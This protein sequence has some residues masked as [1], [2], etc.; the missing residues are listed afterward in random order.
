M[1]WWYFIQSSQGMIDFH[2]KVVAKELLFG[3][4]D[5]I[6]WTTCFIYGIMPCPFT[7]RK[8]FCARPNF[9]SLFK[10]L[11]KYC[12]TPL[13]MSFILSAFRV[14]LLQVAKCFVPVQIL[15]VWPKIYLHI[16]PTT[17]ILCQNSK[18]V[19]C[20][21]TGRKMFCVGPIFLCRTKTLFS[22]CA[23]H[24]HFVPHKKTICIQ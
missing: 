18:I 2:Q 24:K 9:L 16:V 11:F 20:P 4:N 13:K 10:N 17:N 6:F 8:M 19:P 23:S 14:V 3:P 22:Y 12:A 5:V 21:F 7:G 1:I 15:C